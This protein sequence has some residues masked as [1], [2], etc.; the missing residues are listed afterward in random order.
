MSDTA[1][2]LETLL[3]DRFS[4][5]AFKPGPVPRETIARVL[6]IAQRTPSWCN[7]QPWHVIVTS[8]EATEKLRA[9]LVAAVRSGAPGGPDLPFPREYTGVY[10]ARRKESGSALYNA[11]GIAKGDKPAYAKQMLENFRFFGA[12]HVAIVTTDEALGLY[13]ALDCGSYVNTFTLAARALG[14]ASIAQAALASRSSTIRDYFG[15][16]PDRKIVCGV[17]FGFPDMA[18]KANSFRTTRA[19]TEDAARFVTE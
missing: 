2:D 11:L 1:V 5:R 8:G 14:L 12:P 9:A 18:H 10:D 17:S 4:C 13:G 6:A 15:I 3:R 7:S 16:P 19:T